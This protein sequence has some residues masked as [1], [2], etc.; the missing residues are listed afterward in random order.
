VQRLPKLFLSRVIVATIRSRSCWLQWLRT[1][2]NSRCPCLLSKR[3]Q[4][5]DT[6]LS[7]VSSDSARSNAS[8]FPGKNEL[9][10]LTATVP[11]C[12]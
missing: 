12:R 9:G 3:S 8:S 2:R 4:A 11:P 10:R 1:R 7:E 6:M 5:Y